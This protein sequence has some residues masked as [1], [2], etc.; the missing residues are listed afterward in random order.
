MLLFLQVFTLSQQWSCF[1]IK[2]MLLEKVCEQLWLK[3]TKEKLQLNF[4]QSLWLLD[5]FKKE[6]FFKIIETFASHKFI[7]TKL[8]VQVQTFKNQI[9]VSSNFLELLEMKAV[10]EWTLPQIQA[11]YTNIRT[12]ILGS[13]IATTNIQKV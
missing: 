13:I 3:L 4:K 12:W 7:N 2:S 8:K 1:L 9:I 10:K 11:N 5:T 6:F